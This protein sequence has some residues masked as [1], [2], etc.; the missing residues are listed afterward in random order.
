MRPDDVAMLRSALDEKFEV[1]DQ[2]QDRDMERSVVPPARSPAPAAG[3]TITFRRS[4]LRSDEAAGRLACPRAAARRL[5][6]MPSSDISRPEPP[7]AEYGCEPAA[8]RDDDEET[9]WLLAVALI[10]TRRQGA[11]DAL[12]GTLAEMTAERDA[13]TATQ[14]AL[15]LTDVA[16]ALLEVCAD[17]LMEPPHAVLRDVLAVLRDNG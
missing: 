4:R 6:S 9:R 12:L 5:I 13:G 16:A 1:S 8:D 11:R 7:R 14:V 10:E 17:S 2:D 15:G 3:P